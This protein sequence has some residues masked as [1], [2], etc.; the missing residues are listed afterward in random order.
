MSVKASAAPRSA[1]TVAANRLVR[2]KAPLRISFCGG[3]TDVPPYPERFGGCVLSCTIDKYSYVTLRRREDDDVAIR[4]LDFGLSVR[5]DRREQPNRRDEKLSLVHAIIDRFDA[6]GVDVYVH[7]DAPP[8][9]GLGS[10]SSMVVALCAAFAHWSGRD[11]PRYDLAAL[12]VEIER[13]DLGIVGGLQDQYAAVFGGFNY[14]EFRGDGIV[15]NP[16]RLSEPTMNELH[17]HLLLCFTGAT[18]L[19]SHIVADQTRGVEE[20]ETAVIDSLS[21]LKVLTD[22]LKATM[23]TDRIDLFGAQLHEA[24]THKRR[25]SASITNSRIDELYEAAIQAGA[26]GGKLLGAGGGGYL[27]VCT[28]FTRRTA[29]ARALQDRGGQIVDFQ[30]D[31]NGVRSWSAREETWLDGDDERGPAAPLSERS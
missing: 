1:G 7:S 17:Y 4:S 28:P 9:S 26:W 27:L 14:I 11:I 13:N 2:A 21:H 12:A 15:V 16:L 5:Y 30:F 8:G 24:W 19:S 31:L 18:R 20:S 22:R 23:L 25:L 10:S 6:R 3:G 29:V